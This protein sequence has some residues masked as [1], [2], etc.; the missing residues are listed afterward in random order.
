MAARLTAFVVSAIVAITFVAGLIVGAQREDDSGP[1]DLVVYNGRVYVGDPAKGF[2]EAIAIR[3]NRIFRIGS[4]HD[5][6]RFMRRAT[7]TIDAKGGS[8]LPG[9]NDAGLDLFAEGFEL[10]AV[11]QTIAEAHR[12][13]L[14][15]AHVVLRSADDLALL[16]D[17]EKRGELTLRVSAALTATLP[18]DAAEVDRLEAIKRLH[19][20]DALLKVAA[21]R[22]TLPTA[23]TTHGHDVNAGPAHVGAAAP[24]GA[25][26]AAATAAMPAGAGSGSGSGPAAAAHRGRGK[27]APAPVVINAETLAAAITMLDQRGWQVIVAPADTA[28]VE[29]AAAAFEQAL[30]APRV[31]NTPRRHR[32]ELPAPIDA[33][34]STRLDALG[35]IQSFQSAPAPAPPAT[36]TAANTPAPVPAGAAAADGTIPA[37]A[38]GSA[39]GPSATGSAVTASDT[40]PVATTAA[41]AGAATGSAAPVAMPTTRLAPIS[42]RAIFRSDWPARP[43]DPRVTLAAAITEE[44][45]TPDDTT[46]PSGSASER[47]AWLA[48]AID[49]YTA[50]AAYATFDETRKGTLA[51]DMLADLVIF[52]TDLFAAKAAAP[53]TDTTITTTIANGRIVYTANQSKPTLATAP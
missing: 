6:K 51:K 37:M 21:V 26:A 48:G 33:A 50:R 52:T 16:E 9:F 25:P 17:L 47:A 13:G 4:N 36:E 2:A 31:D 12:V 40:A 24:A 7:A 18:I 20:G 11:R 44:A 14:T 39:S 41:A 45:A 5:I 32:I 35:I 38:P 1:I 19:P 10:E 34:S 23:V 46:K 29:M 3:G 42:S 49:A 28:S 15:S 43:L 27:K 30:K 53:V 22:L 8:V